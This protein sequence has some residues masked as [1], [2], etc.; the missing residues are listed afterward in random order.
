[1]TAAPLEHSLFLAI[2]SSAFSSFCTATQALEANSDF[3]K[4]FTGHLYLVIY[5][6]FFL[7]PSSFLTFPLPYLL[8]QSFFFNLSL[9]PVYV[10]LAFM[11]RSC[12]HLPLFS[13]WISPLIRSL[14]MS[15]LA[16]H[17]S[18]AFFFS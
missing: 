3:L 2:L 13:H 11:P 8:I 5:L 17:L 18:F 6:S 16:V 1:M 12:F 14:L 10:Y 9:H 7:F 15:L 4:I